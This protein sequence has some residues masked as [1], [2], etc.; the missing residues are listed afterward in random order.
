MKFGVLYDFRNPA[1][2]RRPWAAM[3]RALCWA[4]EGA[5]YVGDTYRRWYAAAADRPVDTS[6]ESF[7]T[8]WQLVGDAES[9]ID[10]VHAYHDELP[11]EQLIMLV[12][13]AGMHPETSLESLS[14]F[15]RKV[16]PRFK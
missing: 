7:S 9:V 16:L 12:H 4:T 5:A 10:Q 6:E 14:L 13:L 3:Y 8:V 11:F 1:A 2:W 15:S